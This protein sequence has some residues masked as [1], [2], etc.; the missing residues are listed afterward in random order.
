MFSVNRNSCVF[1]ISDFFFTSVILQNGELKYRVNYLFRVGTNVAETTRRINDVYGGGVSKEN[2]LHFRFQ[3]FR[4][5]NFDLQK[6]NTV[7][8]QQDFETIVEADQS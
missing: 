7:G 2:T 1:T 3:R 4:S 5:G 6:T 8:G